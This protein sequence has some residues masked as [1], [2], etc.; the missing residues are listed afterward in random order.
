MTRKK[1]KPNQTKHREANNLAAWLTHPAIQTYLGH[2]TRLR[3]DVLAAILTKKPI[4]SV[5]A[6]HHVTHE[7]CYKHVRRIKAIFPTLTHRKVDFRP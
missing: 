3:L 1:T 7:A 6:E 2:A 5:A 4:A